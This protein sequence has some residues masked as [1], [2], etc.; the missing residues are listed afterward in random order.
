[1]EDLHGK[2]VGKP[3]VIWGDRAWRGGFGGESFVDTHVLCQKQDWGVFVQ[4]ASRRAA[5]LG[6]RLVSQFPSPLPVPKQ[7]PHPVPG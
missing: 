1:M 5:C 2:A 3:S 7:I 4:P 6:G